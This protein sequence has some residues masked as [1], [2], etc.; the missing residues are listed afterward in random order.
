MKTNEY[1]ERIVY[2]SPHDETKYRTAFIKDSISHG[3]NTEVVDSIDSNQV[4]MPHQATFSRN[5]LAEV[6]SFYGV[7]RRA[8]MDRI[9]RLLVFSGNVKLRKDYKER[10]E[11]VFAQM[12]HEWDLTY[13]GHLACQTTQV[14]TSDK[15]LHKTFHADGT[16][17]LAINNSFY[18]I[19]LEDAKVPVSSLNEH[20]RSISLAI[21]MYVVLPP[22]ATNPKL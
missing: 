10:E 22:L 15:Y 5:Q 12:P 6:L 13:W 19:F 7:I 11:M 3:I 17:A 16:F 2:L 14:D 1:F 8:H 4:T 21:Q 9:N 18:H 20:I